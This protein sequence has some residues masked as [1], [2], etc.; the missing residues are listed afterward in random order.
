MVFAAAK[1]EERERERLTR[2]HAH[3]HAR[4]HGR[5]RA[6]HTH[7]HT[8]T[9]PRASLRGHVATRA[10]KKRSRKVLENASVSSAVKKGSQKGFLDG[11]S[12]EAA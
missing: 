5:T 7:T 4:T 6:R 8:H 10:S 11:G 9:H 1:R 12:P 2:T 3:R